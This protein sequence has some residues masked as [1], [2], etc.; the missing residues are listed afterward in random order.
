VEAIW[1]MLIRFFSQS[2]GKG[3]YKSNNETSD[4]IKD[5]KKKKKCNIYKKIGYWAREC[6][7][8]KWKIETIDK[9]KG[10]FIHHYVRRVKD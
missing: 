4:Y 3:K 5:L 6:P 10:N 9:S 7:N 8:K 2:F 1:K